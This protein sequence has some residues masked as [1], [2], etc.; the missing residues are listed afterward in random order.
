MHRVDEVKDIRDKAVAMQVYAKQAQDKELIN[1]VT[2]IR[3]RAEIRAG[4]MLATMKTE[5]ARDSGA[6]GDPP[7]V[8]L[9]P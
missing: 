3:L 2:E 9:S 5:G 6:G 8:A 7:R 4:E 1:Y